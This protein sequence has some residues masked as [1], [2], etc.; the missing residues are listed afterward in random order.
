MQRKK[1]NT[2]KSKDYIK[3]RN[4]F[5]SIIYSGLYSEQTDTAKSLDSISEME[6][7]IIIQ[8]KSIHEDPSFSQSHHY[9][10]S[11]IIVAILAFFKSR[12]DNKTEK[13][14]VLL[15]ETYNLILMI[16]QIYEVKAQ[17]IIDP[18][19]QNHC[20]E[21]LFDI[22]V[23]LLNNC[24]TLNHKNK[25]TPINVLAP[26]EIL[27]LRLQHYYNNSYE[28]FSRPGKCEEFLKKS[29]LISQKSANNR[30]NILVNYYLLKVRK[31][32][33][34]KDV[35]KI[36]NYFRKVIAIHD[37][38]ERFG[39]NIEENVIT[40]IRNIAKEKLYEGRY[41]EAL[42][43][44]E[45]SKECAEIKLSFYDKASKKR[46][47]NPELYAS[48]L[49]SMKTDQPG[50]QKAHESVIEMV[51][52]ENKYYETIVGL[53]RKKKMEL[54]S[55]LT[56]SNKAYLSEASSIANED[57][58]ETKI[59]M[60]DNNQYRSL[61]RELKAVRIPCQID[62][63]VITL[64]DILT[65]NVEKLNLALNKWTE[66]MELLH[67]RL[68]HAKLFE[69]SVI[70]ALTAESNEKPNQPVREDRTQLDFKGEAEKE[71]TV[72]AYKNN[73]SPKRNS[74]WREK[75]NREENLSCGDT[76]D[77]AV[78]KHD[79]IIA[80]SDDYPAYRRA[81]TDCEVHKLYGFPSKHSYVFI[82]KELLKFLRVNDKFA[83]KNLET[84]CARGKV[85]GN[86]RGKK[87]FILNDENA[88]V[89]D[90]TK[91]YRFFGKKT[92]L[93]THNQKTYSL[94]EIN[95]YS[96]RHKDEPIYFRKKP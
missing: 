39:I 36:I 5:I 79:K 38:D 50:L 63:N 58:F 57:S 76:T 90:C 61:Y 15:P 30:A 14:I 32:F 28:A 44:I 40:T 66:G 85:L 96:A 75:E 73:L 70:T 81:D 69:N 55:A 67:S 33:H 52:R 94:F 29:K 71:G 7:L 49:K 43:C 21:L 17:A 26:S 93:A 31:P 20:Y 82:N 9:R 35:A 72:A 89:K 37:G 91:D 77:S 16:L 45:L 87:G 84:M 64:D 86:S 8:M 11:L 6:K 59:V 42:N 46:L 83:A 27:C 47:S 10:L 12:H 24:Q 34:N 3:I 68:Q 25:P 2:S 88:K 19:Y 48:L 62:G 54:L 22:Y 53:I 1:S 92:K 18:K 80:W 4:R 51:K 60:T 13:T 56:E 65:L 41:E 78:E 95:G 23:E 74:K